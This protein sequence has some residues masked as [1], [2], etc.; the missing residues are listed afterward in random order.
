MKK[1]NINNEKNYNMEESDNF[2][3]Y[4]EFLDKA[5]IASMAAIL[6]NP[7]NQENLSPYYVAQKAYIIA[8]QMADYRQHVVNDKLMDEW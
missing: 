4:M 3:Q 5:A 2:D 6:S 8:K 1:N 7:S